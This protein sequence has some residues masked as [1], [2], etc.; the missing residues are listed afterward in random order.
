MLP[1]YLAIGVT[2]HE[3]FHSSPK[4]LNSYTKAYNIKRK[5]QDEQ[6]YFQ[7]LYNLRAFEVAFD[8]VLAG[9]MG[10]KSKAEYF[11]DPFFKE[12]EKKSKNKNVESNEEIAVFE[13]KKRTNL[14][15][16]IGLQ[17]GPS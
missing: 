9:F 5:M 10:K 6:A 14:L 17:E 4:T 11:K 7:G 2:R 3:F 16:R 1:F 12:L 8:H 15:K 13:M